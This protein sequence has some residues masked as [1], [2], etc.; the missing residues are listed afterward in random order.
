M[1]RVLR[2]DSRSLGFTIVELLIV[3][4]IITI[5][6]AITI[7]SYNGIQN[8]AKDAALNDQIQKLQNAVELYNTANGSYPK[9]ANWGQ[10]GLADSTGVWPVQNMAQ[11]GVT[12]QL[13]VSPYDTSGEANSIQEQGNWTTSSRS[14]NG[15]IGWVSI[16]DPSLDA[17]AGHWTCFNPGEICT[18][19]RF[20]WRTSDGVLH[21]IAG[22]LTPPS[23]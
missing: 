11:Y 3:I 17:S 12:A 10:M 13:L 21:T 7:I 16:I 9:S 18:G 19:Y 22:G 15:I 20:W 23:P 2:Y 8:R 5:L 4:V 6:A 14:L 1:K